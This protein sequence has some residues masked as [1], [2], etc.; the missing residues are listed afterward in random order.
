M[1]K[2]ITLVAASIV[3]ALAIASPGLSAIQRGPV[4]TG[5]GTL[6]AARKY[7]EGQWRLLS[8]EVR[9][10]GKAPITLTGNGTLTYDAFGNLT[11]EIQVDPATAERLA[12]G[13]V[14][15]K[16]GVLITSG[17]TAINMQARTLTFLLPDQPKLGAPSG[18]FALNRPRHWEVDG[19]KLTL[20]T[21][22]D[23]G[24]P[25]SIGRWEKV[26]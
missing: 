23:D 19:N 7:L 17:K 16:N 6:A 24:Q 13:G 12:E 1:P 8:Y 14:R 22:G 5:P 4:D 11:I 25:S 3:V 18:P 15:T 20:T 21:H 2:I 26:P 9:L 10:P